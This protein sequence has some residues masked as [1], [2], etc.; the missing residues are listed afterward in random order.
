MLR[1]KL[2]EL[3]DSS[4][5]NVG[6]IFSFMLLPMVALGGAGIDLAHYEATRIEMQDGLDRGVLAAA[7]L[8]QTQ[9]PEATLRDYLKNL[10]Y[11]SDVALDFKREV[12]VNSRKIQANA[13]YTI[14]TSFIHLLGVKALTINVASTAVEAKQ[15]IEMSLML[16]MSGSMITNNRIG[17]L[18]K[19]AKEFID[20]MLTDQSKSFTTISIVPYAGHV[21][22]GEAV[23]N[24]LAAAS[25]GTVPTADGTNGSGSA[26]AIGRTHVYS[27]CFELGET[28][29]GYGADPIDFK[30]AKQ[31]PHFTN[32]N[33][34][35]TNM[36]PW[37]CPLE[38][39]SIT[40]HSNDATALKARIDS[41]EMHD[42]TGTANAMQWGYTLLN[43][44]GK[45]VTDAAI[46]AGKMD[47]K[48]SSRPAAFNDPDTMKIIVLMTDG[49]ITEQ[50]R[51]KDY[52][53]SPAQAP[54][55]TQISSSSTNA[56]RL[57]NVCTKAKTNHITVF[58]IGFEVNGTAT[59]QM[60][61]CASSPGH[62]YPTSGAGISDAFKS[63]STSI[64]KLRLTQ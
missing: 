17:N 8:T 43:P 29:A 13:S 48:F 42:G 39:T 3:R 50:Y 57:S 36:R 20:Q 25:A 59:S 54:D 24:R 33:Y 45:L 62:Y 6:L 28:N 21:N 14:N 37:W 26:S 44:A 52:A 53:R 1:S 46:S 7:S 30:Q 4:G 18:K 19:A 60:T 49:A 32:W 15:S 40:Y 41:L 56:T 63:I 22:V 9:Q 12:T 61:N 2:R 58:T 16:D 35:K 47:A 11:A 5:G 64:K 27:S 51:P 23:F 34:G 10:S 38:S 31:V 55:N